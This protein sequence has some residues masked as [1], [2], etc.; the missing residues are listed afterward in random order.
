MQMCSIGSVDSTKT[1]KPTLPVT[2]KSKKPYKT[3]F[4]EKKPNI[5]E[6][7][8]QSTLK[9]KSDSLKSGSRTIS[10]KNGTKKKLPEVIKETEDSSNK[11]VEEFT[12]EQLVDSWNTIAG[13]YKQDKNFYSTLT[14]HIPEKAEDSTIKFTVDN[15]IQK[16]EIEDRK[17]DI[18]PVVRQKL[19]NYQIRL[20]INVVEQASNSKA[21]FP[22]EKFEKMA[23]KN[24]A[25][26]KLKNQLGLELE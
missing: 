22:E 13:K 4:T 18:L 11:P 24:P 10:I 9:S 2:D 15:K 14:R 1:F 19:N 21:Y 17:V 20:Q 16:K 7:K 8:E 23:E 25:L 26:V 6:P 12:Q 3:N 5:R